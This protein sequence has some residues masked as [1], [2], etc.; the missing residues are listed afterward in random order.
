MRI[1]EVDVDA[2]GAVVVDARDVGTVLELAEGHLARQRRRSW[3]VLERK[4]V[5]W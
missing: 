4:R 5:V 3:S 2:V 1:R